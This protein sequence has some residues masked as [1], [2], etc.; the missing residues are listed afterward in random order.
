MSLITPE[1]ITKINLA[2]EES[3]GVIAEAAKTLG[4]SNVK[5]AAIVH[6]HKDLELRWCKRSN[7]IE[8]QSET[9]LIINREANDRSRVSYEGEKSEEAAIAHAVRK[10]NAAVQKGV[11]AMGFTGR[12]LDLAKAIQE[13]HG[14]KYQCMMESLTVG[15]NVTQIGFIEQIQ[16]ITEE[17]KKSGTGEL[18]PAR[19]MML[20]EDRRGL[21][22]LL[23]RLFDKGQQGAMLQA[24]I[25]AMQE[26][27]NAG[28]G[29]GKSK[30][31]FTPLVAIQAHGNV[32]IKEASQDGPI[33]EKQS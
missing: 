26:A 6:N 32:T 15:I 21:A 22:D 13:A 9:A 23:I 33:S 17:L 30:P 20:R 8:P 5:L 27:K 3:G 24:K 2:M 4:M 31:G 11:E 29:N 1:L 25:R 12:K 28:G 10:E 14:R 16:Q 7:P 18:P 19:E